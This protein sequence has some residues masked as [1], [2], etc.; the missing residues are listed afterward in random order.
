MGREQNWKTDA[1]VCLR[2]GDSSAAAE[3]IGEVLKK[4]TQWRERELV[5]AGRLIGIYEEER[6]V[7]EEHT[8]L[9]NVENLD[10]AVERFVWVKLLFRR[11]EFGLK[12]KYWQELYCYCKERQVSVTM[13]SSILRINIHILNEFLQYASH[14]KITVWLVA[15]PMTEW[16]LRAFDP[17]FKEY[18]YQALESLDY[19]IHH[20]D[21]NDADVFSDSDFNDMGHLNDAGTVKATSILNSILCGTE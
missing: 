8:V 18:Y 19:E 12:E 21:F 2:R 14:K 9:D 16:Y 1:D 6:R 4:E 13:L 3:V 7:G 5:F 15:F 10:E 11:L 17:K 20:I